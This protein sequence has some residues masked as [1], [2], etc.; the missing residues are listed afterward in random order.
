[1]IALALAGCGGKDDSAPT[2][3]AVGAQL[4]NLCDETRADVELLGEPRDTGAA[5]FRPWAR[6]GRE[7]VSAVRRLHAANAT[8]REQLDRLADYYQGFYDNIG[9][10]YDLFE[11]GRSTSIKMTLERAY[12]LLGSGEKLAVRMGA[13]E[14]AVRPFSDE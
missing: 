14:C 7:F 10:S 9:I 12:A 2:R 8:E 3:P 1:M 11:A 6:L 13:P 4:A 5:V